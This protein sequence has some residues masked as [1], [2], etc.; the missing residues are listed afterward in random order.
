MLCENVSLRSLCNAICQAYEQKK[1]PKGVIAPCGY[2]L[3]MDVQKDLM[4]R[5]QEIAEKMGTHWVI[6]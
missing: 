4:T 2:S 1:A 5:L 3:S 6:G